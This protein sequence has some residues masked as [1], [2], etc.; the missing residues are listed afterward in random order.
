[1]KYV[2]AD[3]PLNFRED[4]SSVL[5]EYIKYRSSVELVGINRVGIGNFLRFFLSNK[6][7]KNEYVGSDKKHCFV[8]VDL[9]ELIE[10]SSLAFWRLVFKRIVDAVS[11][12]K[13]LSEEVMDKIS[14]I[15]ISSIQ[16]DDV[17]LTYDFVRQGISILAHEEINVTI[18]LV[19]F[20][21]LLDI[22]SEEL[23]SNME[24]LTRSSGETLS[25]VLTTYR[26]LEEIA[27]NFDGDSNFY[28]Y[29]NRLYINPCDY[30][31]SKVVVSYLIK[32]YEI[33]MSADV[34]K[35]LIFLSGGHV[36]YIYI[37][38]FILSQNKDLKDKY[39]KLYKKITDDERILDQSNEILEN[40]TKEDKDKLYS[41]FSQGKS[42][43]DVDGYLYR[44]GLYRNKDIFSGL[45]SNYL[46][47]KKELE[48]K[49]QDAIFT[50]K[51]NL[52]FEILE[53]NINKLCSREDIIEYV[54]SECSGLGVSDWTIDSLVRRLRLKL[55]MQ[56]SKLTIKTVRTRGFI[57][58]R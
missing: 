8:Y 53:R 48:K 24:S 6:D 43:T 19:R 40:L 18:F 36:N 22:I 21:R 50:N 52:L 54:W 39:D 31:D 44:T 33:D 49:E 2:E 55:K 17:F 11:K 9:Q 7:V 47:K 12:E 4:V 28:K 41:M 15:F 20:D 56:N 38:F 34:I 1:M 46:N 27:P 5:G 29:L 26:N 30:F 57:L 51:E 3:Y 42:N 45:M 35:R 37:I 58:Q 32:K 10:V 23:F 16:V 14:K 25:F 13:M